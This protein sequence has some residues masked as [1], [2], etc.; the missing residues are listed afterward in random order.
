MVSTITQ[1]TLILPIIETG[2]LF[3]EGHFANI[4]HNGNKQTTTQKP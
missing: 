4:R 2:I 3:V 1:Q